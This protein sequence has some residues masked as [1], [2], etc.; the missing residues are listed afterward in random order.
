MRTLEGLAPFW[1]R[2]PSP[3]IDGV[4][5]RG[6]RVE[7]IHTLGWL[8]STRFCEL[9]RT[10]VREGILV[11]LEK[12]GIVVGKRATSSP[13][14]RLERRRVMKD[15]ALL[16]VWR[17]RGA[18]RRPRIEFLG[19]WLVGFEAIPLTAHGLDHRS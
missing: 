12:M 16:G 6:W 10:V 4:T 8:E 3:V 17:K 14:K 2:S 11:P 1:R 9:A 5:R 7:D 19:Q 18:G 15:L 13:R